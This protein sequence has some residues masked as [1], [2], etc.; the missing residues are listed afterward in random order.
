MIIYWDNKSLNVIKYDLVDVLV[1]TKLDKIRIVASSL[2]FLT[3][4]DLFHI[5]RSLKVVLM[6][7]HIKLCRKAKYPRRKNIEIR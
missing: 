1:K 7:E 4:E 5:Y 3:Q 6:Y 2:I